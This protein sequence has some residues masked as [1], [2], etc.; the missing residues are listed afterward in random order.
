MLTLGLTMA[1]GDS[2]VANVSS[3][4]FSVSAYGSEIY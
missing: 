2:I 1:S 4:N 3:S